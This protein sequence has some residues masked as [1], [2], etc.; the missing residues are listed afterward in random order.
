MD[1]L[2]QKPSMQLTRQFVPLSISSASRYSLTFM[3]LPQVGNIQAS[4]NHP[5]SD[6]DSSEYID[7][8]DGSDSEELPEDDN[9]GAH[10]DSDNDDDERT[11][12]SLVRKAAKERAV[13]KALTDRRFVSQ[14]FLELGKCTDL[15][16][17]CY[18]GYQPGL[19]AQGSKS[20]RQQLSCKS[21]KDKVDTSLVPL[22][23][24][25]NVLTSRHKCH[26]TR[27]WSCLV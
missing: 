11:Q 25:T 15:L 1:Y 27:C 21:G 3:L 12:R 13:K 8:S 9:S 4:T 22:S 10:D 17:G 16:E 24:M 7:N 18:L 26:V 6:D 20:Q 5:S 23:R 14:R 19:R 2:A